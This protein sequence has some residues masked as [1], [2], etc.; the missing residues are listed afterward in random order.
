MDKSDLNI[1]IE[2]NKQLILDENIEKTFNLDCLF[3]SKI[4]DR[5]CN[6]YIKEFLKYFFVYNIKTDIQ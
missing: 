4:T 1:E 6:Y 2:F 5:M 3:A